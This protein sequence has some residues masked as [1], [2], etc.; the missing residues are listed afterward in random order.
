[1]ETK[2][3]VCVV[4]DDDPIHLMLLQEMLHELDFMAIVSTDWIEG[5][6]AAM[7]ED[8]VLVLAD[9][10]L[11]RTSAEV[12]VSHPRRRL[13]RARPSIIGMSSDL[14][15]YL[16]THYRRLGFSGFLRKP[17]TVRDLAACIEQANIEPKG[18]KTPPDVLS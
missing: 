1:M 3:R 11:A 4:I 5:L 15:P 17:F 18:R 14:S 10:E 6:A 7:Y 13:D 9:L 12:V 2:R 8:P 16:T